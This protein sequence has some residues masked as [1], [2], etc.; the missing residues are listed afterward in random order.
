MMRCTY[1]VLY[2][3]KLGLLIWKNYL[4]YCLYG[5]YLTVLGSVDSS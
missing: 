1:I 2:V 3:N 5:G 4:T